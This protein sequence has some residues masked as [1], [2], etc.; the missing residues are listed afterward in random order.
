MRPAMVAQRC[1]RYLEGRYAMATSIAAGM[2]AGSQGAFYDNASLRAE[3]RDP[4]LPV[5]VRSGSG[6]R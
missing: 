6:D 3:G 1:L 5:A 2:I 4:G